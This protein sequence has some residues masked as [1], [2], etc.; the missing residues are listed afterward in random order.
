MFSSVSIP[1]LFE[2]F[3]LLLVLSALFLD[4]RTGQTAT[5]AFRNSSKPSNSTLNSS[6]LRKGLEEPS[7]AHNLSF[8]TSTTQQSHHL[9]LIPTPQHD[10]LL[11][12]FCLR[13]S[14]NQ[15]TS[16]LP[17]WRYC[18]SCPTIRRLS[19]IQALHQLQPL[20][21]PLRP[22]PPDL[23]SARHVQRAQHRPDSRSPSLHLLTNQKFLPL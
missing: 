9:H 13:G 16:R 5:F 21:R 12:L 11:T 20:I 14:H 6:P 3:H 22:H 23:C 1:R 4:H 19:P 8:N 17:T 2:I 7:N 18:S 15:Q 10:D